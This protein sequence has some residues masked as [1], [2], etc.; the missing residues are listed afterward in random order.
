MQ[1]KNVWGILIRDRVYLAD[2][3]YA[4]EKNDY[5]K[6]IIR[7]NG[8]TPIWCYYWPEINYYTM[9]NGEVL[10]YIREEM[11]LER[12]N[13]WDNYF[14]FELEV[15]DNE[16]LTG[17]TCNASGYVKVFPELRFD[18]VRAVYKL[19]DSN[20]SNPYWK[21]LTPIYINKTYEDSV[22]TT[23]VLNCEKETIY[24]E[25]CLDDFDSEVIGKCLTCAKS[26]PYVNENKHFC[27][28][29][30]MWQHQRKFIRVAS[31][32]GLDVELA[33]SFYKR[34]SDEDF[35]RGIVKAV[36]TLINN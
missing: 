27:S 28:L 3:Q 21:V 35:E 22:I 34:L 23:K 10:D 32:E 31:K 33:K 18:M 16:I 8:K 20:P 17:V 7:L 1:S 36:R 13:C 6:D 29:S 30:C 19:R 11:S 2:I 12:C 5:T 4:R 14:M 9:Y 25:E 24:A 15:P 26:I